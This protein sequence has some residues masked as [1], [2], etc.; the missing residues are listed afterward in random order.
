MFI[1]ALSFNQNIRNWDV[2]SVTDMRDMF[3]RAGAFNQD[4]CSWEAK[5]DG[6]LQLATGMF[7]DSGCAVQENPLDTD[8][9]CVLCAGAL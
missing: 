6:T 8:N 2:S 9:W 7:S 1:I 4:L 5:T 3:L